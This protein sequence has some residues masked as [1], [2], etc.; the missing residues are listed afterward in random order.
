M[1]DLE[2]DVMVVGAGPTGLTLVNLLGA[3]GVRVVLVERNQATVQ[4]PRA[5]S[6]DDEALRTM[7]A[8]GLDEA[9]I[10]DVALDYGAHYFTASGVCFAKVEPKTREFGFP[11]RSAFVQP[12]LEATLHEGLDRFPDVA[13]LLG[14]TCETAVE[15]DGAVDAQ[16][17]S[18]GEQA[19]SVRAR[20]VVGC[21]GARSLV[22]HLIGARLM[23]STYQQR[24]LIVDLASTRERLR[25]TRVLCNPA[26]PAITLPGPSGIRRYEFMLRDEE[27]DE[28]A[29]APEFVRR[30]LAEHGPDA[31]E[32]VVRRRVYTFHARITDI[33]RKGRIFVAGDAAHL[34]PPFAGQGMN[35]GIRDA[36]NLAWKLA[37]V[38]TGTL[39]D[40][41]LDTYESERAP[42]AAALI[43][44]AVNIG[45]VM[46]PTSPRHAA[47]I[48]SAFRLGSFVPPLHAYFAEMKFKPK[49]FYRQGFLIPV[50]VLRLAGRMFPQPVL[51]LRDRT[52]H[53]LDD[54]A[55]NDFALL[56]LGPNAQRTLERAKMIDFD[57]HMR[58]I[59]VSPKPFNPEPR[60]SLSIIAGR[61][62]DG[63]L[64]GLAPPGKDVLVLL[65]PDRYVAATALAGDK[66]EVLSFAGQVKAAVASTWH[67][68]R[69]REESV[70]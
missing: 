68:S 11:R 56:A 30:L 12:R 25:H 43:Q 38:I 32:P 34:S 3:H 59:A 31:D 13:V 21:D 33:W 49:P 60:G 22:R 70:S 37:A 5:V 54:L 1:A 14:H 57:L 24:W 44:L 35:S 41:V 46:M 48:Q 18:P 42:H 7:Q 62:V 66:S 2:C 16:V 36:H 6:I 15:R 61:D 29:T 8:A 67:L 50:D 10:R 69:G 52:V 19:V 55:G 26:R 27:S 20:Y 17:R 53:R 63:V 45:R 51:E 9:V 58:L 23:G 65:R 4:E 40:G 39:G 28:D 64:D 47:L